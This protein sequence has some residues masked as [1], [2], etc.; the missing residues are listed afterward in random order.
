MSSRETEP[1]SHVFYWN[2]GEG[3]PTSSLS[4]YNYKVRAKST[5]SWEQ[6]VI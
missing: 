3:D 2:C 4:L 5:D 6:E 1:H